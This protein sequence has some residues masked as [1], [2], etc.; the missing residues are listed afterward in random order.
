MKGIIL[1]VGETDT[2]ECNKIDNNFF[3]K[4]GGVA[5]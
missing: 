1:I 2:K 3:A 4:T 5:K